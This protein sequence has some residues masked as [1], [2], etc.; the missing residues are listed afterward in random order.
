MESEDCGSFTRT[1]VVRGTIYVQT[2][3]E[4]AEVATRNEME[5]NDSRRWILLDSYFIAA[6]QHS[7]NDVCICVFLYIYVYRFATSSL[8]TA[9]GEVTSFS[10]ITVNSATAAVGASGCVSGRDSSSCCNSC[11]VHKSLD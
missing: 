2:Y 5:A 10:S 11:S 6:F 9:A 8:G 7:G 3:V 1:A 4:K